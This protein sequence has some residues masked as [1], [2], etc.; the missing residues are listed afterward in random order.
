MNNEYRNCRLCPRS[1]GADRTVSRGFCSESD[2]LRIARA[3]LHL[4]EEPC[5]CTQSGSGAIFFS[6]CTLKCCFCQ[7]HEISQEG[8][9]YEITSGE[10]CEI[11]LSLQDR[12]ACNINLISGTQFI[13]HIK[14]AISLA[15][16]RLHIPVVYNC[17]GYE[18]VETIRSLDGYIDIYLPDLKYYSAELSKEYSSAG[19]YFEV[20]T[21]AIDEMVR[22][23]GKPQFDGDGL[24]RGVMVRHLVL[25]SH[26][27]DSIEIMDYLGK[28]YAS[29]E[30]LL[31]IMSQYTP[32]F[33]SSLHPEID[34]R[35]TTFEYEKVLDAAEKYGFTWYIQG[36]SSARTD[37]IP[38]FYG[39]K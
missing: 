10:L 38:Q 5:I 29:D 19:D 1:C 12:G 28:R 31:S 15:R 13:P 6:G 4:W 11:M 25:P 30:I 20:A 39:E 32:V 35:L 9:G 23:V 37:F 33:K 17:G 8:K 2:R 22:Q 3:D 36:K 21:R 14:E 16:G 24:V 34:R 27:K 18:S 7:N 26:R